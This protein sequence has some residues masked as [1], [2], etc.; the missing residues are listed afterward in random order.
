[1][2]TSEPDLTRYDLFNS[3]E[4]FVTGTGA[5]IIGAVKIDGRV[6][7]DGKPGPVTR[8]LIAQY[9]ALTKSSGEPIYK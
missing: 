7:G 3:D 4:C 6:I 1:M 2:V 5:E 9:Q 8:R